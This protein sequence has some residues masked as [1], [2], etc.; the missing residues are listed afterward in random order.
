MRVFEI[1]KMHVEDVLFF[2][3]VRNECRD[4][5]HDTSFFTPEES[6]E[7]FKKTNPN[8]YTIFLENKKIGYFRTSVVNDMFFVGMDLHKDERGK[9]YAKRL[10]AQFFKTLRE[11]IVY[12]LVKDKNK[13][14][15]NLYKS[16]GFVEI[17]NDEINIDKDSVLMHKKI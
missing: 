5:L 13:V 16:I 12:L 1:K 14:A 3:E 9:G 10:Y 4:M 2:N 6:L 11:N 15:Y 7:W 8:Y 17:S